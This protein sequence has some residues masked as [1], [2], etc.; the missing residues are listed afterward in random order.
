MEDAT[1]EAAEMKSHAIGNGIDDQD[2]AY[3]EVAIEVKVDS[4]ADAGIVIDCECVVQQVLQQESATITSTRRSPSGGDSLDGSTESNREIRDITICLSPSQEA[5]IDPLAT[6][7]TADTTSSRT[8][9]P[10]PMTAVVYDPSQRRMQVSAS[11]RRLI[12]RLTIVLLVLNALAG[13][14]ALI[15]FWRRSRPV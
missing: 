4:S 3:D 2:L 14:R 13:L 10:M 6:V 1:N 12:R 15:L 11:Q 7:T 9:S 5:A 8:R